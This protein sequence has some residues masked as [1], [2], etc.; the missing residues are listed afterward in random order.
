MEG[1]VNLEY[2]DQDYLHLKWHVVGRGL[3][4]PILDDRMFLNLHF[5][6]RWIGRAGPLMWAARSHDLNVN[7][8]FLW[9]FIKGYVF[10]QRIPTLQEFRNHIRQ[11]AEAIIPEMLEHVFRATAA[12]MGSVL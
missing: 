8:H 11:A 7:G 9:G 2:H 12:Q 4:T 5:S 10:T 6:G 3:A 1:V